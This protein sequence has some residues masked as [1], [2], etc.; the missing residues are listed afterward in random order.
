MKRIIIDMIISALAILLFL[1]ACA[2]NKSGDTDESTE[3]PAS[4]TP[5]ED[6]ISE[7]TVNAIN[8]EIAF[9]NGDIIDLELYPDIAPKT[10]ANFID[11]ANSGFYEGTIIHRAV[12]GFVIQGGG[13]DAEYKLKSVS[14]TVV[15]EFAAN[16]IENDLHH[17]RGVI[18]M[19]RIPSEA[20]SASTQFFIVVSDNRESLDGQY[21]AFGRVTR[22]MDVVDKIDR[23]AK[24]MDAPAGMQDVPMGI[25]EIQSVTIK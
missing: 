4:A 17:D 8:V 20:D 11:L 24:L 21:A 16:G 2:G 18:S 15:G 3:P 6:D 10:V 7:L 23:A 19:A 22:G 1:T 25:F 14:E 9:T 13:Y 12:N 5:N